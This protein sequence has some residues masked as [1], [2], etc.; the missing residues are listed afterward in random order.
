MLVSCSPS[1]GVQLS[2]TPISSSKSIFA[3]CERSLTSSMMMHRGSNASSDALNR[4]PLTRVI[5]CW[6]RSLF[7]LECP[8]CVCKDPAQVEGPCMS[9]GCANTGPLLAS[10]E[11]MPSVPS[12]ASAGGGAEPPAKAHGRILWEQ[13]DPARPQVARAQDLC[14]LAERECCLH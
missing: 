4:M 13:R 1:R 8:L 7:H 3:S 6:M 10:R 14:V 9:A 11:R 5:S 12:P 2:S